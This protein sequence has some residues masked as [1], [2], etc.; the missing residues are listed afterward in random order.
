MCDKIILLIAKLSILIND[1][2]FETF[3]IKSYV[4]LIET[5]ERTVFFIMLTMK[6]YFHFLF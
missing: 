2:S 3:I 5:L 6:L 1:L 4:K